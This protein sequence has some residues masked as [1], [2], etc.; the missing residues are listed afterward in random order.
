MD[1]GWEAGY[2]TA[3]ALVGQA[4]RPS[5]KSMLLTGSTPPQS[6]QHRSRPPADNVGSVRVHA[7]CNGRVTSWG[8]RAQRQ[9]WSASFSHR[10]RD[11]CSWQAR[12]THEHSLHAG[13]CKKESEARTASERSLEDFQ[14]RD[15]RENEEDEHPPTDEDGVLHCYASAQ[16]RRFNKQ[17]ALSRR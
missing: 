16:E 2:S 9:P 8:T 12:D 13:G 14:E 3:P 1:R 7:P 11:N 5:P 6:E 15:G 17:R 4:D 10:P